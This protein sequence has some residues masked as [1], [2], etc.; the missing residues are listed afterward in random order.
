MGYV[1]YYFD[2]NDACFQ[3]FIKL[4]ILSIRKLKKQKKE[5]GID[6]HL[7][8]KTK[9]IIYFL[10]IFLRDVSAPHALFLFSNSFFVFLFTFYVYLGFLT[11]FF[12]FQTVFASLVAADFR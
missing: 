2:I 4:G 1:C 10:L 7:S 12:Y 6:M 5:E 9:F 3:N 11:E 8:K